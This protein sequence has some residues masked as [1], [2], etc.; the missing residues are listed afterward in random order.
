MP[1]PSLEVITIGGSSH[2]NLKSLDHPA[3]VTSADPTDA[4]HHSIK[5]ILSRIE[6]ERASLSTLTASAQASPP[7][8]STLIMKRKTGSNLEHLSANP[9]SLPTNLSTNL[10]CQAANPTSVSTNKI[11]HTIKHPGRVPDSPPCGNESDSANDLLSYS[12]CDDIV[13][14][15]DSDDDDVFGALTQSIIKVEVEDV[16]DVDE[17]TEDFVNEVDASCIVKVSFRDLFNGGTLGIYIL[18]FLLVMP[19]H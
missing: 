10:T 15:G 13:V 19:L 14:L 3:K 17:W 4:S 2:G 1:L 7:D 9:I 5:P 16:F 8:S 11:S 18:H 6:I 12:Q